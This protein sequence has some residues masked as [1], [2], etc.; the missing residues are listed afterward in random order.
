M[1]EEA[2]KL[3]FSNFMGNWVRLIREGASVEALRRAV[4]EGET[5]KETYLLRGSALVAVGHGCLDAV[6]F[7]IQEKGL[8]RDIPAFEGLAQPLAHSLLGNA[9]EKENEAMAELLASEVEEVVGKQVLLLKALCL[10]YRG[11][12]RPRPHTTAARR[13]A[14]RRT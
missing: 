10:G 12:R 1:A 11:A 6:R 5:G 13:R 4:D 7:L 9:L 14:S 8:R 2:Q 3:P